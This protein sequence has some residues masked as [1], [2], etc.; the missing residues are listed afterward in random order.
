M[1]DLEMNAPMIREMSAM[2]I[3][4]KNLKPEE[5]LSD[6]EPAVC[7]LVYPTMAVFLFC[8]KDLESSSLLSWDSLAFRDVF[9]CIRSSYSPL[10]LFTSA[11]K[12]LSLLAAAAPCVLGLVAVAD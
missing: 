7:P 8:E 3:R 5:P 4:W 6:P 11:A 12:L 10:S 2:S 9:F 1:A